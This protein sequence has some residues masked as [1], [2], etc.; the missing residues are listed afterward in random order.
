[1]FKKKKKKRKTFKKIIIQRNLLEVHVSAVCLL[2]EKNCWEKKKD[3]IV[4]YLYIKFIKIVGLTQFSFLFKFFLF[5]LFI[6]PC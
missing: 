6:I 5:L 4:H 3:L 1:M 2:V